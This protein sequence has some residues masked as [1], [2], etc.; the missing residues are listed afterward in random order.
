MGYIPIPDNEATDPTTRHATATRSKQPPTKTHTKGRE[1]EGED[2]KGGDYRL[3]MDCTFKT[4]KT[5][6]GASQ[7]RNSTITRRGKNFRDFSKAYLQDWTRVTAVAC[8]YVDG[9]LDEGGFCDHTRRLFKHVLSS[10][11]LPTC[12][13]GWVPVP[14]R[15]MQ[16]KIPNADWRALRE[17]GLFEVKP[18]GE[19]YCREFRVQPDVRESFEAYQSYH[20]SGYVNLFTSKPTE[21][22]LK[23]VKTQRT[24]GGNP[25]PQPDIIR[26]AMDAIPTGYINVWA[27]WE[28]IA[29]LTAEAS[30]AEA[31]VKWHQVIG[32]SE[33]EIEEAKKERA[34]VRGRRATDTAAWHA[35]R[36]QGL[37]H[38]G[39]GIY[40]FDTAYRATRTGRLTAQRSLLQ[41][42]SRE[43]K[44][45]AYQDLDRMRN[46]DIKSSQMVILSDYFEEAGIQCEWLGEYIENG[47]A[48]YEWAERA[49]L[50]VKMWKSCLYALLMGAKPHK[51]GIYKR[52]IWENLNREYPE[53]KAYEKLL[54]FK[55][56]TRP[57][58]EALRQWHGYLVSVWYP[59]N[60]RWGRATN[61][62]GMP[63][64]RAD[65]LTGDGELNEGAFKRAMAAHLLQG[66]EA[67]FIHSL[68]LL[69]RTEGYDFEVISHEHDGI[70]T[71]GEIPDE[72]VETVK[73][74]TQMQYVKLEEKPFL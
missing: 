19:G 68:V 54:R 11:S 26:D 62:V 3:Q 47:R 50:S 69:S 9:L 37:R 21:R 20:Q 10:G 35:I 1:T 48:K 65:Y 67:M 61:D 23:S 51:S 53:E 38:V 60:E 28:H 39:G 74:D 8:E 49:G 33:D 32:A 36:G 30:K 64:K 29:G 55:E 17:A 24:R 27:V 43:M 2:P 71:I 66:R 12:W 41:S 44:E 63:I 18:Y 59:E 58:R 25:T 14:A 42:C 13:N 73:D 6:S 7:G 57:L 15:L 72:A 46:Y 4:E 40:A 56:L 70:V 16:R 22:T 52:D 45:A 34:S 5:P 31:A